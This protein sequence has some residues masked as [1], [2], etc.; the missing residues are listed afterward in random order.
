M[1]D[2]DGLGEMTGARWVPAAE[3][4]VGGWS[5][6]DG[7]AVRFDVRIDGRP[8]GL[9]EGAAYALEVARRG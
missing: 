5:I 9:D 4:K 7:E 1:I 8:A 2:R 6:G 3:R